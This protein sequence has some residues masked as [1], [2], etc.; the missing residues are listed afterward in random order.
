ML[1]PLRQAGD[2]ELIAMLTVS[3]Q[4]YEIADVRAVFGDVSMVI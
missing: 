1:R 4:E 2:A 3:V